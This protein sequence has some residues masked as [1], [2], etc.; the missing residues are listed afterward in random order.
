MKAWFWDD[1]WVEF[2]GASVTAVRAVGVD[3]WAQ[4]EQPN[5]ANTTPAARTT[6]TEA[7]NS[8]ASVARGGP[9]HPPLFFVGPG[10]VCRAFFFGTLH[11]A[12][13]QA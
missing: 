3:F 2:P 12:M 5:E 13:W 4:L 9:N 10:G 11:D 1:S 8:W 6:V 7:L